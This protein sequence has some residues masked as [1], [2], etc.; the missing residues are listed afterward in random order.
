VARFPAQRCRR[1]EDLSLRGVG[2]SPWTQA[3][4]TTET[5]TSA[6]GDE[7]PAAVSTLSD[8]AL[9]VTQRDGLKP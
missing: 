5:P 4:L 3:E 1:L 2:T 6:D 9:A 8:G 7:H